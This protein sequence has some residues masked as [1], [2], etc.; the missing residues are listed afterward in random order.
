MN[1]KLTFVKAPGWA[2]GTTP[3]NIS[4]AIPVIPWRIH[5]GFPGG[6]FEG[7]YGETLRGIPDRH[8]GRIT[9]ETLKKNT[10]TI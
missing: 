10:R 5:G 6:I 3:R 4:R 1:F 8:R 2:S 7:I 9:V